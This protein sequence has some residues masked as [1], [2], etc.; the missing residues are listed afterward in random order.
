MDD[1]PAFA[2]AD[3]QQDMSKVDIQKLMVLGQSGNGDAISTLKS[4]AELGNQ[5]AK[6]ALQNCTGVFQPVPI[7]SALVHDPSNTVQPGS[8]IVAGKGRNAMPIH[9]KQVNNHPNAVVPLKTVVGTVHQLYRPEFDDP[10][11]HALTEMGAQ[12]EATIN[13]ELEDALKNAQQAA[14]E[15]EAEHEEH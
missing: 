14:A 15:A 10:K 3:A 4:M 1:A 11:A 12:I 13:A 6:I 2:E 9:V 7:A 5:D 8:Y